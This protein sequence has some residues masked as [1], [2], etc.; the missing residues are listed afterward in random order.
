[1]IDQAAAQLLVA[2]GVENGASFADWPEADRVAF[3][4]EELQS[5]RP[6]LHWDQSAGPEADA[7]R[8]CYRVLAEHRNKFGRGIGSLIVSMTRQLSD[9]LLVHLFAREAGLTDFVEGQTICPLQVV[10]LFETLD[11]LE[12][13]AG[14][15]DSYL[16]HP[17][18]RRSLESSSETG[19]PGELV[20]PRI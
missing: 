20:W 16:S 1:M 8:D 12:H 6:F 10:R 9:L 15:I 7:V 18:A 2:V 11:D 4:T 3:L 14:I 13:S 5:P 19:P 17:V